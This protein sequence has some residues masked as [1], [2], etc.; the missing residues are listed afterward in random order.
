MKAIRN[1]VLNMKTKVLI[2]F[3][4]CFIFVAGAQAATIVSRTGEA[5][6]PFTLNDSVWLATSWFQPYLTTNATISILNLGIGDAG[7]TVNFSL[8]QNTPDGALITSAD[9]AFD[10]TSPILLPF[11]LSPLNLGVGTFV[12]VASTTSATGSWADTTGTGPVVT[13]LLGATVSNEYL[14]TDQGATWSDLG[15]GVL[16]LGFQVDAGEIVPTPEP[17]TLSLIGA[18]LVMV[19]FFRRRRA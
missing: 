5:G 8:H 12:L 2:V 4:I 7:S 15:T 14:S 18:G 17:A 3:A 1:K 19:G 6:N 10:G 9:V 13:G 11:T 16:N